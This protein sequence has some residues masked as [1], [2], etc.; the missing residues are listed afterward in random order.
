VKKSLLPVTFNE[1]TG[2]NLEIGDKVIFKPGQNMWGL[3][4]EGEAEGIYTGWNRSKI[5]EVN[6]KIRFAG[7][8]DL[9]TPLE[10]V[11]RIWDARDDEIAALRA[12][13]EHASD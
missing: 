10:N 3:D 5:G 1:Q 8:L 2:V 9:T 6:I 11:W 7:Y 4:P 13:L 12:K